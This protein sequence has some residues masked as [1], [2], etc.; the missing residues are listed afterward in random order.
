[1]LHLKTV[2][3]TLIAHKLRLSRKYGLKNLAIFGSYARNQL[4]DGSDLD[5]LVEF[6]RIII[7]QAKF[8]RMT[9]ISKDEKFSKFAQIIL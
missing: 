4:T 8:E 9:V 3:D 1:M 2:K 6:D 5:I 7:A